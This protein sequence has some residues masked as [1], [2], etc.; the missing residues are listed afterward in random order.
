MI[1]TKKGF[2]EEIE[3]I[4]TSETID[5]TR[6]KRSIPKKRTMDVLES[7]VNFSFLF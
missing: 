3:T 4:E 2:V 6:Q 7:T 5:D 1:F